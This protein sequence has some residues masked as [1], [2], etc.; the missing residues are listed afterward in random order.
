MNV[1][2]D[3]W[4]DEYLIKKKKRAKK[5]KK[6][7]NYRYNVCIFIYNKCLNIFNEMSILWVI[8]ISSLGD[9]KYIYIKDF[10]IYI[11]IKLF[12]H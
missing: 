1:S 10:F 11:R 7:K 4:I 9:K 2:Y 3:K 8:Y 12:E 6:N 5:K